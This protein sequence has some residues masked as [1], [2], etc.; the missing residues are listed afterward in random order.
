[1]APLD[2]SSVAAKRDLIL[3]IAPTGFTMA[4]D[5]ALSNLSLL[6]ISVTYYTIVKS[7]VPLWIL[8]FSILMK[9][10]TPKLELLL[11]VLCVGLGIALASTP[12]GG[13]AVG[14]TAGTAGASG[15]GFDTVT[16]VGGATL[17]HGGA[18]RSLRALHDARTSAIRTTTALGALSLVGKRRLGRTLASH[19][20]APTA[21]GAAE[22]GR[23]WLPLGPHASE[24]WLQG[25]SGARQGALAPRTLWPAA[26]SQQ[27]DEGQQERG[28]EP[29]GAAG[30]RPSRLLGLGQASPPTPTPTARSPPPPPSRSNANL[31]EA[32]EAASGEEE[33]LL[34]CVLVLFSSMCSGFRWTWT[35][36][37]LTERPS[38]APAPTKLDAPGGAMHPVV[39]LFYISPFGLLALLPV[40]LAL[41]AAP[42]RT[43]LDGSSASHVGFLAGLAA[44]GGL[45]S[46]LMLVTEMQVVKLSSGLTLSV[47][48]I[49]KELLTVLASALVLG[50]TLTWHNVS[51]LFLCLVG[52][53]HYTSVKRREMSEDGVAVVAARVSAVEVEVTG[54]AAL[55][56]PRRAVAV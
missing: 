17:P 12:S 38:A 14:G 43:Y 25:W 21:T 54:V 19:T 26:L 36:L 32:V 20:P 34:G 51:G 56:P 39:L 7:S 16:A 6:Y 22:T 15:A 52:I 40:A 30:G 1:M 29:E 53:A 37:L 9:L 44:V 24:W 42:L 50:D 2:F 28:R 23:R 35:Q 27:Q 31:E 5:I 45:V 10:Q 46:C 41:E 18:G 47:S 8:G 11:T 33:L 55:S 48:G 13:G 3:R 4:G 49:F